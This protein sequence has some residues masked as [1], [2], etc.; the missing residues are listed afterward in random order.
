MKMRKLRMVSSVVVFLL[1]GFYL[2]GCS[3]LEQEEVV[4]D[5]GPAESEPAEILIEPSIE[6]REVVSGTDTQ[7]EEFIHSK[8]GKR[9]VLIP[10]TYIRPPEEEGSLFGDSMLFDEQGSVTGAL[11]HLSSLDVAFVTGFHMDVTEVTN[12]EFLRFME[13]TDHPAPG[14]W[15]GEKVPQDKLHWP[16]EVSYEAA[17]SYAEWAGLR[18]PEYHEFCA[19]ATDR[20]AVFPWRRDLSEVSSGPEAAVAQDERDLSP[21]GVA[22]LAGNALEWGADGFSYKGRR[23][24]TTFSFWTHRDE[25]LEQTFSLAALWEGDTA[26]GFRCVDDRVAATALINGH[27]V[28]ERDLQPPELLVDV[29]IVNELE[30]D[31][32][33]LISN[34]EK[35][36]CEAE[37]SPIIKLPQ[38]TYMVAA[39]PKGQQSLVRFWRHQVVRELRGLSVQPATVVWR[40]KSADALDMLINASPTSLG[41]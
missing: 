1:I 38:G 19:A 5:E 6:G 18:I 34:G 41:E 25:D 39:V 33:L 16:V 20:N 29:R 8:T 22:D 7:D 13:A 37:D 4:L 15:E 31:V 32:E 30:I 3:L 10:T 2:A 9:M 23:F 28:G 11:R 36:L 14:E 12:G 26:R 27:M 21:L 40:I 17:L 35:I 24:R